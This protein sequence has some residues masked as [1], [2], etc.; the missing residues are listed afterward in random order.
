MVNNLSYY[1]ETGIQRAKSGSLRQWYGV[2]F[3]GQNVRIWDYWNESTWEE[4]LVISPESYYGVNPE[5]LYNSYAG[6]N[7]I[8]IGDTKQFTIGNYQYTAYK[9]IQTQSEVVIPV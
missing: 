2:K 5:D 9:D 3:S 8:I 7:K 6:T 1:Q 4:V